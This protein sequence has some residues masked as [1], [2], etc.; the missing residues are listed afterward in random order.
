MRS[1]LSMAGVALAHGLNAT[2]LRKSVTE[3]ERK[4]APRQAVSAAAAKVPPPPVFVPLALQA[5]AVDGDT[6]IELQR[7]GTTLKIVWPAAAW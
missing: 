7:A 4:D 5:A 3:S 6:R 1:G 2:M